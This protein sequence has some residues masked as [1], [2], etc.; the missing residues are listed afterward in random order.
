[1]E[2]ILAVAVHPDD[3]TLGCGGTLLKHNAEG[4]ELHWLILTNISEEYGWSVEQVNNREREIKSVRESYSFQ[5]VYK[6]DFPTTRLD[7]IPIGD[8]V[9]KVNS[10]MQEVKPAIIYL[11]NRS[12]IHTDHQVAF[13]AVMSCTKSFH[14]PFIRRI[15]MYETL[16]ESEFAPPLSGETF[17]PNVFIDI[18]EFFKRKCEIM[19]LYKGEVL[20]APYPRSLEA[21]EALAKYRGSR[22]GVRYAEAFNLLYENVV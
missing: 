21:L 12:D 7:T 11:N 20:D 1:M 8:I 4:K 13:K 3:E 6:L 9:S 5:S 14:Y 17:V 10:V 2:K 18:T 22:S 19:R 16:S 15:L